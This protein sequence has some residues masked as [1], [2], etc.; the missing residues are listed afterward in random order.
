MTTEQSK[1]A[2]PPTSEHPFPA[3]A[4]NSASAS[5]PP[6][7]PH[8][9]GA[10]PPTLPPGYPPFF[11]YPP[12]NDG[13]QGEGNPAPLPY[14]LLYP[15]PGMVYAFPPPTAPAATPASSVSNSRPKRRQVK[16]AC[17]NCAAACKRCDEARPCE[18][19]K[20][21]GIADSCVDGQRKE[22]KKGIKRGPYKRKN[23]SSEDNFEYTAQSPSEGGEWPQGSPPPPNT[24]TTSGT[25]HSVAQFPPVPEGLYPIY[26]PPGY[27]LPEPQPNV[28]GSAPSGP[29]LV[30][31]YIGSFAPYG[32]PPGAVF[33]LPPQGT[34]PPP[35][36]ASQSM[37]V[38]AGTVSTAAKRSAEQVSDSTTA[39]VPTATT[40]SEDA[41][42][43]NVH[44]HT[45]AG[46]NN[47]NSNNEAF[48]EGDATIMDLDRS[49]IGD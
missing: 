45:K 8:F 15:P 2:S 49:S 3:T 21:Y 12:P 33:Q 46:N 28:D 14:P 44:D 26:L 7:F 27:T 9:A 31:F 48:C 35:P 11:A 5:I 22:R 42:D 37:T 6:Q 41:G 30:P 10:Y 20:K 23:K 17:T 29:T 18:R 16:M 32:L 13:Q 39:S 40:I 25:L 1:T 4:T 43:E 36:P 24:A 19:C 47:N 38:E 34:H